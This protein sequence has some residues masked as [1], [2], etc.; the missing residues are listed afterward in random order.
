MSGMLQ[1][2]FMHMYASLKTEIA[3]VTFCGNTLGSRLLIEAHGGA[4]RTRLYRSKYDSSV[5][6]TVLL[7][8]LYLVRLWPPLGHLSFLSGMVR[9]ATTRRVS[10]AERGDSPGGDGSVWLCVGPISSTLAPVGSRECIGRLD[11]LALEARRIQGEILAASAYRPPPPLSA[12]LEPRCAWNGGTPSRPRQA[13]AATVFAEGPGGVTRDISLRALYPYTYGQREAAALSQG[14]RHHRD[15]ISDPRPHAQSPQGQKWSA[16]PRGTDAQR[17]RSRP[18]T[19]ALS[20]IIASADPADVLPRRLAD[21]RRPP[22]NQPPARGRGTV[23]LVLPA[24]AG[25]R[26]EKSQ[27]PGVRRPERSPR[28]A[29]FRQL[30]PMEDAT[31]TRAGPVIGAYSISVPLQTTE[32]ADRIAAG[33]CLTP[34]DGATY[35]SDCGGLVITSTTEAQHRASLLHRDRVGDDGGGGH[36]GDAVVSVLESFQRDPVFRDAVVA[37]VL[38][39]PDRPDGGAAIPASCPGAPADLPGAAAAAAAPPAAL[40][41]APADEPGPVVDPLNPGAPSFTFDVATLL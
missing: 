13:D 31:E 24:A 1:H 29:G 8:L 39:D 5:T 12:S 2:P 34:A 40:S 19:W 33:A 41:P 36:G 4:L 15:Q 9:E 25:L 16:G 28:T 17:N 18:S 10:D 27:G 32:D 35:C 7:C 14:N 23:N 30:V 37:G 11:E 3:P 20:G 6:D 38:A 22:G 26:G 21:L